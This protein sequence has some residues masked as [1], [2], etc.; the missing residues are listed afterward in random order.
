M[1][2]PVLV[3]AF[4]LVSFLMIKAISSE[5]KLFMGI[6]F[7]CLIVLIVLFAKEMRKDGLSLE[8]LFLVVLVSG[9]VGIGTALLF[10][11]TLGRLL[12]GGLYGAWLHR[13]PRQEHSIA[14][15][16]A[17]AG[18]YREAI[19]QYEKDL[20]EDPS[21]KHVR[22]EIATIY[23]YNLNEYHN[24]VLWLDQILANE[25][26]SPVDLWL[27]ASFRAAELYTKNLNNPDRA[28]KIL[29]RVVDR[30]PNSRHSR[31]AEVWLWGPKID[32]TPEDKYYDIKIE[33]DY[34]RS[35]NQN[36][37]ERW[38]GHH[39]L[40]RQSPVLNDETGKWDHLGELDEFK[41]CWPQVPSQNSG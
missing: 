32:G 23:A 15:A 31:R 1:Y 13:K 41:R 2:V 7:L 21:E 39:E 30:F 28:R 27:L 12:G 33:E 11:D 22:W 10:G 38:I 17:F 40:I 5:R 14:K 24:A 25:K 29:R 9:I 18:R 6:T 35:V 26:E 8:N 37:V 3:S 19:E 34:Y 4:V 20:V 36:L 16:H